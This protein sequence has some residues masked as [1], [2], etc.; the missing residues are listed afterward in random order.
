MRT[1]L[2]V[3]PVIRQQLH[4]LYARG[5][6]DRAIG[7]AVGVTRSAIEHWRK[8]HGF[9][10]THP[11]GRP[12]SAERDEGE[13]LVAEVQR[14]TAEGWS[15]RRI[16]E[17]VGYSRTTISSLQT[18]HRMREHDPM[19][20]EAD[21]AAPEADEVDL[22][23]LPPGPCGLRT[24]EGRWWTGHL[25]AGRQP[26]LTRFAD[27]AQPLSPEAADRALTALQRPAM[28]CSPLTEGD[29]P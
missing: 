2:D 22:A 24:A 5:L 15:C 29:A 26:L 6:S 13:R 23:S 17:A 25:T 7:Y 21:V 16:G 14:M 19:K 9:K 28:T 3:D 18:T 8:R 27:Y 1:R 4:E 20:A 12:R 10:P 11:Q